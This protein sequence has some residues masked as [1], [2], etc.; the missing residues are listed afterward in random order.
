MPDA[1]ARVAKVGP[2]CSCTP[3]P[4]TTA[5]RA[6]AIASPREIGNRLSSTVRLSR[7]SGAWSTRAVLPRGERPVLPKSCSGRCVSLD[8]VITKGLLA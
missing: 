4:R 3:M 1:P 2:V 7:T 5:N 8:E 6:Y